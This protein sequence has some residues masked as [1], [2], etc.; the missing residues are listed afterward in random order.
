VGKGQV[1]AVDTFDDGSLQVQCEVCEEYFLVLH[2]AVEQM[3]N[4]RTLDV[5]CPHCR[6]D[7]KLHPIP[8]G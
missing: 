1:C 3:K 4:G 8:R 7:Y 2:P 5:C 6:T